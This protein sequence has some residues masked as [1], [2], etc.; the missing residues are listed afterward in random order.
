M[1]SM[2]AMLR[3]PVR[4]RFDELCS[5]P[6]GSVVQACMPVYH[7]YTHLREAERNDL[8][9]RQRDVLGLGSLRR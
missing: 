7:A 8:I 9:Y 4:G 3:I 5:R 6:N 1:L 2:S